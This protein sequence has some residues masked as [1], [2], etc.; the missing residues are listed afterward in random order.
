MTG[1]A[2]L[3]SRRPA[4]QGPDRLKRLWNAL[5]AELRWRH[6]KVET[7]RQLLQVDSRL[8]R[9]AGLDGDELLRD[10]RRRYRG[11]HVV[12]SRSTLLSSGSILDDR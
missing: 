12:R 8:L 2:T 11:Q 9:D 4:A 5:I 1:A 6:R 10:A 7:R 3:N